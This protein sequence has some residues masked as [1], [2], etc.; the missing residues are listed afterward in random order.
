M[1]RQAIFLNTDV[2]KLLRNKC[3]VVMGDSVQRSIYKDIVL[4]LQ[5]NRFLINK[6]L[7]NKGEL[8]FENDELLEGGK[9]EKLTNGT[10]YRE[11]R[12]YKTDY[13]LVR[14]YFL[15]RVYNDYVE[16][17]LTDF[18][19]DP[20]PDVIIINSCL[21]DITRYGSSFITTYRTNLVKLFKR[22]QEILPKNTMIIWNTAMPVSKNIRGGFLVPEV[23]F[24]NDTLRLDILE[25]NFYAR[26]IVVSFKYDVL[27][28]HYYFRWQIHRRAEDGIH[29]NERAHRRVT[30]LILA[31]VANS[32]GVGVPRFID[33]PIGENSLKRHTRHESAPADLFS[34]NT[35]ENVPIRPLMSREIYNLPT[36][37]PLLKSSEDRYGGPIRRSSYSSA[38]YASR[39]ASHSSPYASCS[40]Q[41]AS[42]SSP[43][44]TP[45]SMYSLPN[46]IKPLAQDMGPLSY[47]DFSRIP[48][49]MNGNPG[50]A[51]P[52]P[53][54]LPQGRRGK[55]NVHSRQGGR[56]NPYGGRMQLDGNHRYMRERE[57]IIRERELELKIRNQ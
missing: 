13:H 48:S 54:S 25:A 30:N 9:M 33:D 34:V 39:Y 7:R 27:D 21:W 46:Q 11:V 37:P 24:M 23:A 8:S 16:T 5:Q 52:P 53:Q 15:T 41:Y 32:W 56:Y 36:P 42:R 29:W 45:V 14:F 51:M 47:I 12:Q 2:R 18:Q 3:I 49:P 22:F 20:R 17:V 40:S 4:L 43:Y 44:T 50:Q 31:H 57:R 38:S 55:S 35:Q 10:N 26:D 1:E 19:E 6:E 28:L